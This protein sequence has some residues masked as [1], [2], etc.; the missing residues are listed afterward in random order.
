MFDRCQ[1]RLFGVPISDRDDAEKLKQ[2]VTEHEPPYELAGVWP[3][4]QSFKFF[5]LALSETKKEVLPSTIITD[6]KGNVLKIMPGLPSASD[7]IRLMA[8]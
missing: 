8:Y 5:K 3:A 6:A 1:L 7:I 2:Y 4:N